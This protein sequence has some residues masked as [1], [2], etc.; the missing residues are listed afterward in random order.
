MTL[1]KEFKSQGDWLFKHRSYLPLL[2]FPLIILGIFT[3][4][5]LPE[6]QLVRHIFDYFCILISLLGLGIRIITVGYV[7]ART[8]GRNTQ[9]Q[10]ADSLNTTGIYSIVRHPLYLGNFLMWLGIILFVQSGWLVF[11]FCLLYWLYYE[12]IMYA[13]ESFLESKFGENFFDW[14]KQTPAFFPDFRKWKKSKLEFS[15]KKVLRTENSGFFGMIC[16]FTLLHVLM[17]FVEIKRFLIETEWLVIFAVSLLLYII[18]RFLK[19][20]TIILKVEGR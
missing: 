19:K 20:K 8:S 6:N 2:L 15:L 9:N 1:K 4:S 13:E 5:F 7:P 10:I 16:C 11:I 3:G 17:N 14:S 12:R 18:L